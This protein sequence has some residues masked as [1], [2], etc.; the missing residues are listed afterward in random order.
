MNDYD[1]GGGRGG[2]SAPRELK[3]RCVHAIYHQD[4]KE[5]FEVN[6]MLYYSQLVKSLKAIWNI[7]AYNVLLI[8]RWNRLRTNS[9][10]PSWIP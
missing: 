3:P 7:L 2:Q 1:V 10:Q 5:I 6:T 8:L 4:F 9:S